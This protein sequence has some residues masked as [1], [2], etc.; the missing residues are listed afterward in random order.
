M[1]VQIYEI[2]TPGEAE[3]LL[4]LGVD[5]IGSVLQRP[6]GP[7]QNLLKE[8]MAVVSA[9][10]AKSSLIPLFYDTDDI[11]R[12]IDRYRPDIVHFCE[13]LHGANGTAAGWEAAAARQRLIRERFPGLA[14]MR[15]IP[16]GP[17]G[18]AAVVPTLALAEVFADIS[19]FFLTDTFLPVADTAPEEAQ[20]EPGFV[21]ITGK[22]CDWDMAA[23]L[24]SDS[25]LPVFLAGGISPENVAEA[26]CRVAPAGVDSCTLTN[27]TGPDGSPVRFRKDVD[28][29]KR[30]VAAARPAPD[31]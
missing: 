26:I 6:E 18:L 4:A 1:L 27:Q 17:T 30:L 16:I 12:A 13:I 10:G 21:G 20:P 29:V 7:D 15:S 2:Q 25:P 31:Q 28:K 8:T 9:A 14:L 22:T 24:V 23:R 3:A 11:S 19:D 5:H